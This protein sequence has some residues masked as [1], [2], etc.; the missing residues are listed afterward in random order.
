MLNRSASLAMSTSVLKALPGKLDIKRHSPSIL[1]VLDFFFL[2]SLSIAML[3]QK[4]VVGLFI[5]DMFVIVTCQFKSAVLMISFHICRE[6]F[7]SV[8]MAYPIFMLCVLVYSFVLN[9]TA[10][11]IFA[12]MAHASSESS[13]KLK[14]GKFG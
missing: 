5:S 10:Y 4:E 2:S 7:C 1:Y 6:L 9:K 12:L 3:M 13:E 11:D 8:M 14:R